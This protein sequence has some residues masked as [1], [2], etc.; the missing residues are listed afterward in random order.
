MI[1]LNIFSF[2]FHKIY[3]SL[4]R[5]YRHQIPDISG[6]ISWNILIGFVFANYYYYNFNFYGKC[7]YLTLHQIFIF[8]CSWHIQKKWY[9]LNGPKH[10]EHIIVI[11]CCFVVSYAHFVGF[12]WIFG[13]FCDNRILFCRR[14][15][16]II[17]IAIAYTIWYIGWC[18]NAHIHIASNTSN[19]NLITIRFLGISAFD[20]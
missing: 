13:M 7:E 19:W 17:H 18:K 12:V 2:R 3:K 10:Y 5:Y 11:S 1:S 4:R 9:K 15:N 6:R 8:M 16:L 14:N 20:T